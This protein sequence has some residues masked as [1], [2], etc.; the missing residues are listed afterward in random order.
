MEPTLLNI[1]FASGVDVSFNKPK[2]LEYYLGEGI[3][4]VS[5]NFNGV[6]HL[7]IQAPQVNN[8]NF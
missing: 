2:T 7:A 5:I 6:E 1:T 4:I 8:F 3:N